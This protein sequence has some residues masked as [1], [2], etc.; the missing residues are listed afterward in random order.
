[1]YLHDQDAFH[2]WA[3]VEFLGTFGPLNEVDAL[4]L[5]R[6]ALYVIELKHWQGEIAGGG[7]Q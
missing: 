3:N 6:S 4:V 5:T 1:M 2:V 7:T